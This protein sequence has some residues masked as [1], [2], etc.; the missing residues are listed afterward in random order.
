LHNARFVRESY[1]VSAIPPLLSLI[2]LNGPD[3][4]ALALTD[5]E[6]LTA[7]ESGLRAQGEGQTVI[8]PRMHLIPGRDADGTAILDV[9]ASESSNLP[10]CPALPGTSWRPSAGRRAKTGN[11]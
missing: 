8:E 3:V 9:R 6:I 1:A 4:A 11:I 10:P 2:Y 7:V 5:D